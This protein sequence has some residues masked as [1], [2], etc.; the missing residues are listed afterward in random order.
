MPLWAQEPIAI[1]VELD[2]FDSSNVG[3]DNFDPLA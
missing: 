1:A 2:S 3:G